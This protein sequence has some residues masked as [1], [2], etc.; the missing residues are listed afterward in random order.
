ME[1]DARVPDLSADVDLPME[2]PIALVPV[3][4]EFAG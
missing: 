3:Q 1:T 2:S 4:L